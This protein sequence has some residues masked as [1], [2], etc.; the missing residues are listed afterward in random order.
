MAQS[1]DEKLLSNTSEIFQTV[2]IG[3]DTIILSIKDDLRLGGLTNAD[4]ADFRDAKHPDVRL[5]LFAEHITTAKI[6]S[7]NGGVIS[8]HEIISDA[9]LESSF[10]TSGNVGIS[11]TSVNLDP[12]KDPGEP[13]GEGAPGGDLNLYSESIPNIKQLKLVANGGKGGKGQEGTKNTA[14]GVGGNG[15]DSGVINYIY[16]DKFLCRIPSLNEAFTSQNISLKIRNL[17]NFLSIVASDK[18]FAELVDLVNQAL[19]KLN[20]GTTPDNVKDANL[21]IQQVMNGLQ[22]EAGSFSIDEDISIHNY[23]GEH[24]WGG[25]GKTN[26]ADGK[27]GKQNAKVIAP[28]GAVSDLQNATKGLFFFVHPSQLMMLLEKAKLMYFS[29]DGTNK[30]AVQDIMVLLQRIRGRASI[31]KNL[32]SKSE[33]YKNYSSQELSFGVS[34]SV[35]QLASIYDAA[36]SYLNQLLQGE[37]FFGYNSQYVPMV[38]YDEYE[39]ILEQLLPSFKIVED[40]YNSYYQ[41]LKEQ[42]KRL[43]SIRSARSQL[44]TIIANTISDI[45]ILKDKLKDEATNIDFYQ[46]TLKEKKD[47]ALAAIKRLKNDVAVHFDA[48]FDSFFAS[49]SMIAFAPESKLMLF[50]EASKTLYDGMN[51]VTDDDGVQVNKDYL[52]RN[53]SEAVS[54]FDGLAEGYKQNA[55][56]EVEEYDLNGNMLITQEQQLFNTIDK[57]YG[58]FS[59]DI[60]DLKLCFSRYVEAVTNRNNHILNY[61]SI[62]ALLIK[63][64]SGL[65]QAKQT[66]VSLNDS[67]LSTLENSDVSGL[68]S[69]MSHVYYSLRFAIMEIIDLTERAFAFWALTNVSRDQYAEDLSSINYELLLNRRDQLLTSYLQVKNHFGS[70]AIPFPGTAHGDQGIMVTLDQTAIASLQLTNKINFS[71]GVASAYTPKKDNPFADHANVRLQTVRVWVKGAITSDNILRIDIKHSGMEK[72]VAPSNQIFDFQHDPRYTNFEYNLKD[73]SINQDGIIGYK[74]SGDDSTYALIGP[75]TDW[76]ITISDIANNGLDL[77]QVEEIIME[78]HGSSYPFH[79]MLLTN[80]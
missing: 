70:G 19:A 18:D 47:A 67:T 61:N 9:D 13:G 5:Y 26:G 38:A 49:M 21:L 60:D 52:I 30:T 41:N 79:N 32:D 63:K 14:P 75:F 62:L 64:M 58:T 36:N 66:L 56:G 29:L 4:F 16:F 50:T 44:N 15:G 78:F 80:I 24:G 54:T 42:K 51:K 34:N 72:I 53:L 27:D 25:L 8:C 59:V 77:S 10:D 31:F 46:S 68:F 65:E 23:P 28:I 35:A 43:D 69:Y 71:M 33:L 17:Q 73:N 2:K 7:F 39:K 40:D 57:F 74:F 20:A 55:N 11:P 3:D 1:I 12:Q 76:H 6:F 37:D 45:D 22:A 48:N